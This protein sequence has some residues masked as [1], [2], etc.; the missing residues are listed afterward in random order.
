MKTILTF[1]IAISGFAPLSHATR[2]TG[3]CGN[4]AS[5]YCADVGGRTFNV[6]DSNRGEIG[7]CRLPDDS[8]IEAHTL[9]MKDNMAVKAFL[10]LPSD[11][12][13]VP[14][15]DDEKLMAWEDVRCKN[16]GGRPTRMPQEY[17]P[18]LKWA[19]CEF[20]DGSRIEERTLAFGDISYRLEEVLNQPPGDQHCK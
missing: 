18:T 19:F 5:R 3:G 12:A 14:S 9:L 16:A 13:S 6:L 2:E 15:N 17:Y 4:P 11:L 20:P 8:Y 7:I 1:L 10:T